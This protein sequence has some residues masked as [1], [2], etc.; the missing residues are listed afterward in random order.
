V[1]FDPAFRV[2]T[3]YL[4]YTLILPSPDPLSLVCRVGDLRRDRSLAPRFLRLAR[5]GDPTGD[6]PSFLRRDVLEMSTLVA[7]SARFDSEADNDPG[8]FGEGQPR[9][10]GHLMGFDRAETRVTHRG[11]IIC[12][13]E[14][15]EGETPFRAA[16]MATPS[17]PT[18]PVPI[19]DRCPLRNPTLV[20]CLVDPGQFFR[21]Y[22]RTGSEA[23]TAAV[24]PP[25]PAPGREA[26]STVPPTSSGPVIPKERR[27]RFNRKQG[28]S[29]T[30]VS[31]YSK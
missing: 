22:R 24:L 30:P 4:C 19:P 28:D 17:A 25:A 7:S 8:G 9:V 26:R 2:E 18:S 10:H 20:H 29:T 5:V 11:G 21:R 13:E 1:A 16:H 14:R 15:F 6:G 12:P 31:P 27:G 3:C 23:G